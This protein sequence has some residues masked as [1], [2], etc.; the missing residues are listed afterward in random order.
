MLLPRRL[1]VEPGAV[2]AVELGALDV[3]L[4]VLAVRQ[5]GIGSAGFGFLNAAIGAGES[6]AG[7]EV[8]V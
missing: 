7:D 4:M 8:P 1:R 2:V 3:L 6:A 5:L